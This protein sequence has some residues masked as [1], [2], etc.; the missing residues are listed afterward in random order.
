M[1]A[2]LADHKKLYIFFL[3][4]SL[5]FY[6]NCIRN[7]FSFDDSYVTVTNTP[8]VKGQKFTPNNQL[9]AK[10]IKGIPKIWQ[11]H[12]G[13]GEGTSYDYR[14]VVTSLFAIEYSLFGPAPHIYHFVSIVLY[15][16]VVFLLF[17]VLK[18]SLK[19]YSFG[20]LFSFVCAV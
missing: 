9:V 14:P 17:L 20:T 12:Y 5:L 1:Q 6:G 10:G 3:A 15:S 7:G 11:S 13:H 19:N 16:L 2:I 4:L 8:Q 18:I